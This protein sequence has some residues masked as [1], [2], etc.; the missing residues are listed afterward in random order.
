MKPSA[1]HSHRITLVVAA[2][3]ALC[4]HLA[5]QRPLM[6][7]L[8]AT[9]QSIPILHN[10]VGPPDPMEPVPPGIWDNI[11]HGVIIDDSLNACD[12]IFGTV[13]FDVTHGSNGR[14][15]VEIPISSFATEHELPHGISL[16]Y[17]NAT[18]SGPMG[19]GWRFDGLPEI[20]RTGRSFFTD[21]NTSGPSL[22]DG[23]YTLNGVRLLFQGTN[24]D[25]SL[26][27]RTQVGN[28][29]ATLG[30]DGVFTV[31]HP[32]GS[33][34]YF[35]EHDSL[36][37]YIT[38]HVAVDGQAVTYTYRQ[39]TAH[40]VL[41]TVSYGENRVLRMRYAVIEGFMPVS[42]KAGVAVR[43]Q[44]RLKRIDVERDGRILARYGMGYKSADE[45][46][47]QL[48][49]VSLTDSARRRCQPL[50]IKYHAPG[51]K[52]FTSVSRR[53]SACHIPQDYDMGKVTVTRGR[54]DQSSEDDGLLMYPNRV[55]YRLATAD[56]QTGTPR[57]VNMYTTQD[58]IIATTGQMAD[59]VIRCTELPAGAG[60]VDAVTMDANGRPG[61]E[62]V[63]VNNVVS[64]IN[65]AVTLSVFSKSGLSLSL[66]TVLTIS[67]PA[68]LLNAMRYTRPKSFL[69]GN[70]DGDGHQELAMVTHSNHS[71]GHIDLIGLCDAALPPVKG[72]FA[73]DSC[74]LL[75]PSWDD[76]SDAPSTDTRWA[77]FNGSDRVVAL[78]VDGGG[79]PSLG[80]L[81]DS[82]LWLHTFTINA[83]GTR[84]MARRKADCPLT[85]ADLQYR[86]LRTGDFNGDG[87][88]DLAVLQ[89]DGAP[90]HQIYHGN[91]AGR[92]ILAEAYIYDIGGHSF[93]YALTDVDHDGRTDV[94]AHSSGS[95]FES[96]ILSGGGTDAVEISTPLWSTTAGGCA[97]S[98][99][100]HS[101]LVTLDADGLATF[102][103][104]NDMADVRCTMAQV[105]DSLTRSHTFTHR[106]L[107]AAL[108]TLYST[109]SPSFPFTPF[110]EGMLV[111]AGHRM[112][113]AG[114]TV[115]NTSFTYGLPVVHRQ[116]MGFCGF[117]H[118]FSCDS[119]TGEQTYT[120]NEPEKFGA[121]RE[122][123]VTNGTTP[124]SLT[125]SA[126]TLDI[127]PA[128]RHIAIIETG[129][130]TH[131]FPTA[132]ADTAAFTHDSHG[133]LTHE[134]HRLTG[135]ITR[136][137]AYDL[138]TTGA[139]A[140]LGSEPY[141]V[142]LETQRELTVTAGGRSVTTGRV[143]EYD[144]S[145]LVS[146][147]TDYFG[148]P[149]NAVLTR[150]YTRDAL[151]RVTAVSTTP[152]SGT[153]LTR[154][155]TYVGGSRLPHTVLD[156]RN[157][158][159]T[160]TWG[161]YGLAASAVT[162]K[163]TADPG[164]PVPGGGLVVNGGSGT[165]PRGGVPADG[166]PVLVD[167]E[168]TLTT[169]WHRGALGRLDSVTSPQG[170][171]TRITRSWST[172]EG[173]GAVSLTETATDGRPAERTWRDALG[174]TVR[175]SVQRFDGA[176]LAT[177][178]AYDRRGRLARVSRPSR[179]NDRH[180][181][182][183]SYDSCDR[184]TAVAYPDGHIDQTA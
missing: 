139:Q 153:P 42:Y 77:C 19:F 41:E 11:E 85:L 172:G 58:S 108:D 90:Y 91:G 8:G 105:T 168:P 59:T 128:D 179:N 113:A 31:Y 154:T 34:D 148:S 17:D 1:A 175:H 161:D 53:L 35:T 110:S 12:T 70:F 102:H 152:Y 78:D 101:P 106:R 60:F 87:I 94:Y 127:D 15:R 7:G 6:A 146:R 89:I 117:E 66:D 28:I 76:N 121:P 147:E 9:T 99:L 29:R 36:R 97:T 43:H 143:T 62:L 3:I 134:L 118:V 129:R 63:R 96:V 74:R 68:P 155:V 122:R 10:P 141:V 23:C 4:L 32:D 137:V 73:L 56:Q 115:G 125:Q 27:F 5:A 184:P 71:P 165:G 135:G 156:E 176:W 126:N 33:R 107:Y 164:T 65:D 120:W 163:L 86:E 116:G 54:F 38:R 13:P 177:D 51:E 75:C 14:M 83:D 40:K 157:L 171:V 182:V 49:R 138:Y 160:L 55:A 98:S 88:T 159:T 81:N 2:C 123:R 100:S 82:G 67:R 145:C 69:T 47:N 24:S 45:V 26:C 142:G 166:Q 46:G 180:W 173:V 79:K 169:R 104:Y 130:V 112:V 44:L 22:D 124:L 21:G 57:Y 48:R 140:P 144:D 131:D 84:S 136:T 150:T 158:L 132:V 37:H 170:V 167:I 95:S 52:T 133:C 178:S 80:V 50:R 109:T 72:S 16:V 20:T 174:R 64:G 149:G 61:D 119:V 39:A 93:R 18:S 25:G 183:F 103:H 162:P 111:C 92:Y 30:P 114:D 181:T 151:N